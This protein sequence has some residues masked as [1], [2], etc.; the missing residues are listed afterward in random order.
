MWAPF[1]G[2]G[3]R[4]WTRSV[5]DPDADSGPTRHLTALGERRVSGS[6]PLM[7][8]AREVLVPDAQEHVG[9]AGCVG[10]QST[11]GVRPAVKHAVAI[12][13]EHGTGAEPDDEIGVAVQV[14]VAPGG[15]ADGS[16]RCVGVSKAGGACASVA[17]R[18][19]RRDHHR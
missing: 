5:A 19:D 10:L 8:A 11:L 18:H 4:R 14:V 9:D 16:R 7:R 12:Q 17:T 6:L 1:V 15:G 13:R 2:A 3:N